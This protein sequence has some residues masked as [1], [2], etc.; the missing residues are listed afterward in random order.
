[1]GLLNVFVVLPSFFVL[2]LVGVTGMTSK[3]MINLGAC[4]ATTA[5]TVLM[6]VPIH[7]S[8]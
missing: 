2:C 4:T 3:A 5:G 1:M 7:R 6:L 8:I